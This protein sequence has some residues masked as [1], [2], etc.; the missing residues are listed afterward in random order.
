MI[1]LQNKYTKC[2]F[3][4]INRAKTRDNAFSYVEKHHIIPECFYKLR[5]RKG[6]AGWIDGNA[7]DRENLVL[8]T[9]KEHFI[10]HLLLTKMVD[11]K[12]LSKMHLALL[13]MARHSMNQNRH[14][15]TA[16]TY[17]KLRENAGIANSG[18]NNPMWGKVRT[19]EECDRVSEG[20]S[21]S[22]KVRTAMT[23]EWKDNISAARLAG[24]HTHSETTKNE[25]SRKRKGMPGQD[26]N[27]GK[28]WYND[29][30]KSY[31]SKECPPNCIVGR[32]S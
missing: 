22:T 16:K 28:H 31:L 13:T 24:K 11:G 15:I 30:I 6:P 14:K 27:S 17:K 26:N 20:I 29:G 8:L 9:A 23:Q 18:P 25:W 2:Y 32:L 21:K 1:Y 4:I 12:N 7:N 3:S 10:C 5:K 19:Q